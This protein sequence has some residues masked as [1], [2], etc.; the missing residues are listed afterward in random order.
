MNFE[1]G[2]LVKS[3]AGR[4]KGRIYAVIHVKNQ[5]VYAAD[6]DMHPLRSLKK[7]N[8]KHLQPILK[9]R[10]EDPADDKAVRE[11]IKHY[12]RKTGRIKHVKS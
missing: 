4:D 3:K 9:P 5:Y 11:F 2:M 7:K 1:A 8:K 10:M 6:G 12:T